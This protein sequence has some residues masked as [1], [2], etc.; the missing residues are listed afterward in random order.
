MSREM[1][2]LSSSHSG[3]LFSCEKEP[4]PPEWRTEQHEWISN[5]FWMAK[6]RQ[7]KARTL[8]L[9]LYQIL[10]QAKWME[11]SRKKIQIT[12]GLGTLPPPIKAHFSALCLLPLVATSP[13]LAK[14]PAL[15]SF[16]P[17]AAFPDPS[18]SRCSPGSL[19]HS[20][21]PHCDPGPWDKGSPNFCCWM[22]EWKAKHHPRD[23]ETKSRSLSQVHPN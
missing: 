16:L 13:V 23:V 5:S 9:H 7:K 17:P 3:L 4:R 1:G 11:S 21:L 15:V 2:G 14:L 6:A 10:E 22:S 20:T 18:L 8:C 19:H 12:R